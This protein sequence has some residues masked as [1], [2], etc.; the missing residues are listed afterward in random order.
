M[1]SVR[2]R[3]PAFYLKTDQDLGSRTNVD[4]D[5]DPGNT[6]IGK[7]HTYEGAKAFLKARKPGLLVN[8][9]GSHFLFLIQN[10]IQES[11]IKLFAFSHNLLVLSDH[12]SQFTL[13]RNPQ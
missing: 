8:G 13:M 3:L 5:P 10:W 11:Q 1:V 12:R 7:K 2:N 4:P 9:S 6:A